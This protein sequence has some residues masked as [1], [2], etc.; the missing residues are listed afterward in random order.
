MRRVTR[1]RCS[2]EWIV[3]WPVTEHRRYCE[4]AGLSKTVTDRNRPLQNG[5]LSV[6][7]DGHLWS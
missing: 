1:A 2:A 7:W 5:S 3:G 4:P 6:N